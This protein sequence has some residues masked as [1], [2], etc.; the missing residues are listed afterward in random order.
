MTATLS[1]ERVAI[2]TD[3]LAQSLEAGE[4]W[5]AE[6][7][8]SLSQYPSAQVHEVFRTLKVRTCLR[9]SFAEA[10]LDRAI[11]LDLHELLRQQLRRRRRT[12]P[13]MSVNQLTALLEWQFRHVTQN[14][15]DETCRMLR[16]IYQVRLQPH[17]L[18]RRL[19]KFFGLSFLPGRRLDA[20]PD[21][22][23][24]VPL[25][26]PRA[27]T[28]AV[29]PH[30]LANGA[31]IDMFDLKLHTLQLDVESGAAVVGG[32]GTLMAKFFNYP[33]ITRPDRLG[34]GI[35]NVAVLDGGLSLH[36]MLED[37][38]VNGSGAQTAPTFPRV[39]LG[40]RTRDEVA[41]E[42]SEALQRHVLRQVDAWFRRG[43][44]AA[45]QDLPALA[46]TSIALYGPARN[47]QDLIAQVGE[48]TCKFLQE[49][50]WDQSIVFHEGLFLVRH[51]FFEPYSPQ[52]P[53][54][55]SSQAFAQFAPHLMGRE[56][57]QPDGERIVD[58]HLARAQVILRCRHGSSG[59]GPHD[60]AMAGLIG[61]TDGYDYD[62]TSAPAGL[63][64]YFAPAEEAETSPGAA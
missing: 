30:R 3:A 31:V 64:H 39:Y 12:K 45:W 16:H 62:F 19:Q 51:D 1:P 38:A 34:I 46:E 60:Q 29:R 2:D 28:L 23:Q 37:A 10:A 21:R 14:A 24:F 40:F 49:Q 26:F 55:R 6:A 35:D 42:Y 58:D 5:P 41:I 32:R 48:Q 18:R 47:W 57:I 61:S 9:R 20:F 13:L 52:R 25:S 36:R 15:S 59:R 11:V 8:Q 56:V 4:P 17:I 7:C 43:R 50:A 54:R 27:L 53:V 44:P 63:E 33:P 22:E